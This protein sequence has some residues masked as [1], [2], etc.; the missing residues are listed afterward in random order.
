MG[1]MET[2]GQVHKAHGK[3]GKRKRDGKQSRRMKFRETGMEWNASKE[4]SG[5]AGRKVG[6]VSGRT[7]KQ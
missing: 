7:R 5:E 4:E 6:E 3:Y 1:G 2:C